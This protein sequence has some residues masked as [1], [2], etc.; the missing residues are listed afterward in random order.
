MQNNQDRNQ[1]SEADQD[2]RLI[3]PDTLQTA[4]NHGSGPNPDR[5]QTGQ[6]VE[7]LSN[8]YESAVQ[9]VNEDTAVFYRKRYFM[10]V[11]RVALAL[12]KDPDFVSIED[13]IENLAA[14]SSPGAWHQ[15][16]LPRCHRLG[17]EPARHGLLGR[18]P[19]ERPRARS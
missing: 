4:R 18:D 16:D 5:S 2:L 8:W 6:P 3:H 15:D 7:P 10:M 1:T 11:D 19:R 13:L 14:R 9:P 12:N 17:L